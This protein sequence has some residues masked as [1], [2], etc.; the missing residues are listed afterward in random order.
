[1]SLPT[2]VSR[3][4]RATSSALC[5]TKARRR[6]VGCRASVSV[7]WPWPWPRMGHEHVFGTRRS[8][9]PTRPPLPPPQPLASIDL[10]PPRNHARTYNATAPG[11]RSSKLISLVASCF[12]AAYVRFWPERLPGVALQSTPVFDGRCVCYP[13][14]RTVRDYLSWRQVD[15]H[16]NNQVDGG[17][18]RACALCV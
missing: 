1:M 15:T 5:S 8:K 4:A 10:S 17:H 18:A 6:T 3:L 11:R 2:F 13:S 16:V 9:T 14:V 7:L 12:A